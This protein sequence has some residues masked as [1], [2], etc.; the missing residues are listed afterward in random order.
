MI[1]FQPGDLPCGTSYATSNWLI[2]YA[3]ERSLSFAD[4]LLSVG[5]RGHFFALLQE[6]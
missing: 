6:P 2:E 4:P 1:I 3:K 5:S